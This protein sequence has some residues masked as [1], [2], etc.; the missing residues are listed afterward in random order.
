MTFRCFL[1]SAALLFAAAT[2]WPCG[3]DAPRLPSLPPQPTQSAW[4]SA[5]CQAATYPTTPP[6]PAALAPAPSSP[7]SSAG[8]ATW[9]LTVV[10][11]SLLVETNEG[12]KAG[13]D[14]LSIFVTGA[15]P[16]EATVAGK[17]IR[18]ASG[19]EGEGS[20]SLR[21]T[22]NCVTRSGVDGALLT[23]EGNAKLVYVRQGKK[24]EVS[25]DR[26]SVNLASGQVVGEMGS[27]QM[28]TPV[29]GPATPCPS[30]TG[31]PC[32]PATR[33]TPGKPLDQSVWTEST[34]GLSR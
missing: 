3:P 24:A 6:Q 26:V 27:S 18:V 19:K 13:C 30:T 17:Q 7:Y 20:D 11:E 33:S 9:T 5:P 10:G 22:A 23:L 12:M 1:L 25:A 16:A 34:M 21:G 29:S 15:A 14:K 31:V 32:V 4:S 2:A 8:T 28:V